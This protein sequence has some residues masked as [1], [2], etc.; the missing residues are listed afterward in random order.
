MIKR[1]CFPAIVVFWVV[2]NPLLWHS[3]FGGGSEL[4][5]P[6][7]VELVLGK[8]FTSADDSPLEPEAETRGCLSA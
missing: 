4:G 2:M 5:S 1:L 7:P 8:I 3:E 6:V